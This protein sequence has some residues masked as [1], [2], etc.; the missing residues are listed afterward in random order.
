MARGEVEE[1]LTSAREAL[2]KYPLPD[3]GDTIAKAALRL[4]ENALTRAAEL[5]KAHSFSEAAQLLARVA[6][7]TGDQSLLLEAKRMETLA[8]AWEIVAAA[9][10]SDAQS[11]L[12][13]IRLAHEKD[14]ARECAQLLAGEKASTA[15]H[16]L[17]IAKLLMLG[18]RA[19]AAE[20]ILEVAATCAD[21]VCPDVTVADLVQA[22]AST[23]PALLKQPE[24]VRP[25]VTASLLIAAKTGAPRAAGIAVLVCYM[26]GEREWPRFLWS[27]LGDDIFSLIARAYDAVET[28]N[29]SECLEVAEMLTNVEPKGVFS[30]LPAAAA[31]RCAGSMKF[32]DCWKRAWAS[33][34]ASL[35]V[36]RNLSKP[37]LGEALDICLIAAA[38][39]HVAQLRECGTLRLQ[40]IP[41]GVYWLVTWKP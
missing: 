26:T 37:V 10:W 33:P 15:Y 38:Q 3:A 31:F 21:Q 7:V 22:L 9:D 18:G 11:A 28:K 16:K 27:N 17:T 29:A 1:A 2:Q 8:G 5:G 35:L 4:V 40:N 36:K 34:D 13:V 24:V 12:A 14:L 20:Q 30:W 6:R 41:D 25:L 39:A 32:D 23:T 19:G